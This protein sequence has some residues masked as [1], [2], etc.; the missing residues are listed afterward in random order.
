MAL[1]GTGYNFKVDSGITVCRIVEQRFAVARE[2]PTE[3]LLLLVIWRFSVTERSHGKGIAAVVHGTSAEAGVSGRET[4][5]QVGSTSVV[6]HAELRYSKIERC[7]T[8]EVSCRIA[9]EQLLI[10]LYSLF[11]LTGQ[12][13]FRCFSE[14]VVLFK[15]RF[16]RVEGKQRDQE[17]QHFLHGG[18]VA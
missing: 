8:P 12:A 4:C 18:F 10:A 15:I 1:H 11:L 9:I 16:D 6:F 2:C 14:Q 17:R 7:L 5:K 13:V 3:Q